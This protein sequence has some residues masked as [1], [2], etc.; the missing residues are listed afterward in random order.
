MK[1]V[2]TDLEGKTACAMTETGEFRKIANDNYEIGQTIEIKE[3]RKNNNHNVF[4]KAIKKAGSVAAAFVVIAG[5]GSATAYA[6]PY[7]T[8]TLDS[9]PAIEYTVNCFNYVIGVNATDEA[10]EEVLEGIDVKQLKNHKV[11]DAIAVTNEQ[12]SSTAKVDN[13]DID[14]AVLPEEEI[15]GFS[16]PEEKGGITTPQQEPQPQD[17]MD[18]RGGEMYGPDENEARDEQGTEPG[19]GN[20]DEHPE[21]GVRPE[22]DPGMMGGS[23]R[24]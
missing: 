19:M 24:N 20:A 17:L 1:A 16:E 6:L 23:F 5:V 13:S 21:N 9:E 4:T 12:I 3:I 15:N 10:G 22:M 2:I 7:D 14:E 8:V 18:G 11:E